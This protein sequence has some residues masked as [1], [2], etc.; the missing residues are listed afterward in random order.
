[1]RMRLLKTATGVKYMI[2]IIPLA[3]KSP[4]RAG[5]LRMYGDA[6]NVETAKVFIKAYIQARG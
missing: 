4:A 2:P 6:I 1:M 5:R 3:I